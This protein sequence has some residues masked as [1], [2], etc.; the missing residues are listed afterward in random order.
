MNAIVSYIMKDYFLRRL[1]IHFLACLCGSG[2][3]HELAQYLKQLYV[4]AEEDFAILNNSY[5]S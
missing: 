4:V 2:D 3:F 5:Y 1:S